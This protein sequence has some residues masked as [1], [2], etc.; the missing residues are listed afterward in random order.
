M[1]VHMSNRW[2]LWLMDRDMCPSVRYDP[3]LGCT[4]MIWTITM[5]HLLRRGTETIAD[6]GPT[7]PA[8]SVSVL[9]CPLDVYILSL[10]SQ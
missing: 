4:Q 10:V 8:C 5:W 2:C 1:T 6:G 9:E 7:Q 3:V